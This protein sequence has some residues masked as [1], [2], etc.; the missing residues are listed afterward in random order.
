MNF[1]DHTTSWLKGEILEAALILSFG[2]AAG[3]TAFLFWKLGATPNAKAL[4]V[5]LVI[6][7]TIYAVIGLSM[8][9]ANQNRMKA[10]K[11][12]FHQ[13]SRAFIQSEKK[14]VEDFQYGYT[15]SKIVATVCFPLTLLLFWLPKNP[16]LQGIG[17]G[18]SLFALS[19]LV[20]DYF[21]QERA[22]TY[23]KVITVTMKLL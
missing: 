18:L 7:G 20:V 21:S 2:F 19:G 22:D 9:I 4:L 14:R 13:D 10:F 8:L 3:L 17:I 15:V 11:L 1:F 5:S 12:S 16:T 23:Y 6:T